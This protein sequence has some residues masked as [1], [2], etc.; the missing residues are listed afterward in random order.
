METRGARV[1]RGMTVAVIAVVT[2][3]FS[4]VAAGGAAPGSLGTGLALAFAVLVSIALAGRRLSASRLAAAVVLSQAVFHVLFSLGAAIPSAN[5]HAVSMLGMVMS[6]GTESRLPALGSPGAASALE[7]DGARMWLGHAVAAVATI[8]VLL[9]G[10]R[11]L[12]ALVRIGSER[13]A[14]LVSAVFAL[15]GGQAALRHQRVR[16]VADRRGIPPLEVLLSARPHRGP[17]VGVC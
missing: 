10:E 5:G 17:P 12:L 2:A 13:L 1:A 11:S 4:H 3:A 7:L 16:V 14:V 8:V 15:P 6:G 9:H